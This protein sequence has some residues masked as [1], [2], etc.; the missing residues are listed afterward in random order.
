[1][2]TE[3]R[4]REKVAA[5]LP[6]PPSVPWAATWSEAAWIAMRWLAAAVLIGN[7]FVQLP[8]VMGLLAHT[9]ATAAIPIAVLGLAQL[10]ILRHFW[11]LNRNWSRRRTRTWGLAIIALS[12]LGLACAA[13]FTPP[14]PLPAS[15]W[16]IQ[17][18]FVLGM[19]L[20]AVS[21]GSRHGWFVG[22]ATVLAAGG[23]MYGLWIG[24]PA[25]ERWQQGTL[26]IG[27]VLMV[28]AT[29]HL[30]MRGIA[31]YAAA[32]DR[33][34]EI[35]RSA[36]QTEQREALARRVL[37][38]SRR[39]IHDE[40]MHTLRALAMDRRDVPAAD[41]IAAARNLDERLS[42]PE[43]TPAL[44]GGI[45][46]V[47]LLRALRVPG[48]AVTYVGPPR[49]LVVRP[50]ASTLLD[51]VAECLRNIARHA[52]TGQAWVTLQRRGADVRVIVRDEGR[53]FDMASVDERRH[54][55]RDSIVA[56]MEGIGGRAEIVSSRGGGTSITLTWAPRR[57][58]AMGQQWGWEGTT[59][60]DLIDTALWMC[61]PMAIWVVVSVLL[62]WRN[63]EHPVWAAGATIVGCAVGLAVVLKARGERGLGVVGAL[64]LV[65]TGLTVAVVGMLSLPHGEMSTLNN[66]MPGISGLAAVALVLFR[67][68]KEAVAFAVAIVLALWWLAVNH[69][70]LAGQPGQYW[71]MVFA[72]AQAVVAGLALRLG[73][74]AAGSRTLAADQ[75]QLQAGLINQEVDTLRREVSQHLDRVST[76][77]RPFIASVAE[78]LLD[79]GDGA[80]RSR[81]DRLERVLRE[82]L[83]LGY[84][85]GIRWSAN[86][87]RERGWFV[88]VR[89]EAVEAGQGGSA[90]P[91]GKAVPAAVDRAAREL[92]EQAVADGVAGPEPKGPRA[93]MASSDRGYATVSATTLAGRTS[94]TLL[95][96][97]HDGSATPYRHEVDEWYPASAGNRVDPPPGVQAG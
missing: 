89:V 18:V 5:R 68:K 56:R 85:P 28:M 66:P 95:L 30:G 38:E 91:F 13:I 24:G 14:Q 70:G 7:A 75:A 92:T 62:L 93:A 76:A 55:I 51:A 80:V 23:V 45:D 72:P 29:T 20:I 31:R 60:G 41:A 79:V 82:D 40:V 12:A 59:I 1:M 9:G 11:T 21:G 39:F 57:A 54:G 19:Y 34:A 46:L 50:V 65:A 61:V 25:E 27:L 67:P 73:L 35:Q 90:A 69:M 52:G 32:A 42:F 10:A 86:Q 16:P 74:D 48:V 87:L 77:A 2:T 71:P 63:W 22:A 4:R 88:T 78:G 83:S 37:V 15:W 53:G 33:S 64:F 17:H 6:D 3:M 96:L 36:A 49:A 81:A 8:T 94:V 97:A 58:N 47:P 84:A 26:Q 43:E 44:A